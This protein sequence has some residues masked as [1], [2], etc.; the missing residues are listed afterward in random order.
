MSKKIFVG[1]LDYSV[2]E[3]ELKEI[4][5]PVGEIVSV[6]VIRDFNTGKSKG[7]AFIEL[8]TEALVDECKKLDGTDLKGRPIKVSEARERESRP[9]GNNRGGGRGGFGGGYGGGRNDRRRDNY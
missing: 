8:S 5:S 7:F 6:K 2:T 1:N 3:I 4:F 9:G